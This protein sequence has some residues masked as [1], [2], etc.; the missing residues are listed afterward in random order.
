MANS[1][2][3]YHLHK[4]DYSQLQFEIKSMEAY[5]EKNYVHCVKPHRH[6]FYQIIWFES[7]PSKHFIDFKSHEF[8]QEVIFFVDQGQVHAFLEGDK[9]K[10]HLI[11]FNADF[12]PASDADLSYNLFNSWQ[13]QPYLFPDE[14]QKHK[15]STLRQLMEDE[16]QA[17]S[18]RIRDLLGYLLKSFLIIAERS[19]TGTPSSLLSSRDAEHQTY[20]QFQQLLDQHIAKQYPV[21]WY[22][23]QLNLSAKTLNRITQQVMGKSP[24]QLIHDR[25]T[26]EAKRLLCQANLSVKEI[27]FDLGFG[28]A[29]YFTKFFKKHSGHTPQDFRQQIA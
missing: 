7:H 10:G 13:S 11:H 4:K 2:Q 21:A 23:E 28:Q 9:P 24:G 16:L 14:V 22:S 1:I 29:T 20:L 6:T 8:T 12:V 27:A 26:L 15:L 3:E 5:V 25:L 18:F 19:R 17:S